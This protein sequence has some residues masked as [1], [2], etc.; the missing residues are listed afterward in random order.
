MGLTSRFLS[1][2]WLS[3]KLIN[4]FPDFALRIDPN[5]SI[6]IEASS[7]CNIRCLCCLVGNKAIEGHNMSVEMF[8]KILDLLPPHIRLLSF[9][10]RGDPTMNPDLPR[11][12][13]LAYRRGLRT[14]VYT[15]GLRLDRHV[16]ELVE[17]GVSTIRIDLDGA[18]EESYGRYR[19]GSDFEKVKAN[20]EGLVDARSKSNGKF[21]KRII[22]ICVVSAFNEHE[23]TEI[24]DMAKSL[25]VDELLFKTAIINYGT[26]FY[27]DVG[28]QS[29][30]SPANEAYRRGVRPKGFVCPFLRRGVI[31]Y[32][33]DLLICTMDFEGA[34]VIGNILQEGSFSKVFHSKRARA[35]R[36]EIVKQAG[37][38]CKSCA[39]VAHN[40]YMESISR[41][42]A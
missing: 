16:S 33:G 21:P 3:S 13:N 37:S 9:S 5:G 35:I 30:M 29:E 18:S 31:L 28:A 15:N 42:F 10:H 7:A 40:H 17:S 1:K 36:R 39:V 19:I 6:A 23:I 2:K 14:D 38:L 4:R 8:V 22:I 25:G 11:M 12:L 24:Q 26:K 20:I 41:K 27:N 34:Y 32:N